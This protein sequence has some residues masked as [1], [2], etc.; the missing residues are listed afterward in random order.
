MPLSGGWLEMMRNDGRKLSKR[1]RTR[2]HL[3]EAAIA[4]ITAR[5]VEAASVQ[6]IAEVAGVA[7]GTFYNHFPAKEAILEA[8]AVWLCDAYSA[9]VAASY[10]DVAEGAERMAIGNRRYVELAV[11]NPSWAALL[12]EILPAAPVLRQTLR[13]YT[14]ADLK[15]GLRQRRHPPAPGVA[16]LG[17]R[18]RIGF[19]PEA[20]LNP[21]RMAR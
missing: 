16:A 5:G 19:D 14:L 20:I 2:R 10:A 8:I 18:L 9:R 4:V 7:N 6:E 1:E 3:I 15:L 17:A 12:L 13:A 11:E 21:N